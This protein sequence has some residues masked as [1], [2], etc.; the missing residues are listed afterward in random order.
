M[1]NFKIFLI[2]AIASICLMTNLK[3]QSE[4]E[5]LLDTFFG[6]FDRNVDEAIDYL[7]STNQLID[8]TQQGIKAIKEKLDISR[9]L[10][11]EYYGHEKVR[12][13][14]AGY[15][16]RKYIYALKYERQP[17]KIEIILYKPGEKWKVQNVNFHDDVGVDF[18]MVE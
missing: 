14:E 7:F 13:F 11:G 17:L 4:P 6:I 18:K 16:Y 5:E 2:V 10:L 15:S 8:P 9:R 3:A 1:R 12:E